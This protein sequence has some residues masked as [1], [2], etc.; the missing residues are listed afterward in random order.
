[1]PRCPEHRAS[2]VNTSVHNQEIVVLGE[3]VFVYEVHAALLGGGANFVAVGDEATVL[4]DSVSL[5]ACIIAILRGCERDLRWGILSFL[6]L[7]FWL[8]RAGHGSR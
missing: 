7:L 4:G 1:M 3:H 2:L 5:V 6:P 8:L